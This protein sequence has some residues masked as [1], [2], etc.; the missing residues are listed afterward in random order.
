MK[1]GDVIDQIVKIWEILMTIGKIWLIFSKM[2]FSQNYA[3][4]DS[5]HKNEARKLKFGLEV[6]LYRFYKHLEQ[7]FEFFGHM[8]H[9]VQN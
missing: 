5:I 2:C 8:A 7:I 4:T 9:Y 6:P 3:V 1:S